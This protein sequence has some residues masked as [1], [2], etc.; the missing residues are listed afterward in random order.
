MDIY[1]GLHYTNNAFVDLKAHG[2]ICLDHTVVGPEGLLSLLELHLGIHHEEIS[3]TDRQA[4]YYAAFRKVMNQGKN[5]LTDSWEKNGL[6]VSNECLKWRDAL[7]GNGWQAQMQQPSKRLEV[8]SQVEA[9]FHAPAFGDRLEVLHPLLQQQSPLPP[10]SRIFVAEQNEKGL[11]PAIAGLLTTLQAKGTEIVY[12]SD[13]VLAA[14][15]SNLSQVQKLL[16]NHEATDTLKE[17]DTS[18]QIWK[19]ATELDAARFVASCPKNA[20]NVYVTAD[21]KLFDNVQRMLQQ[22]TSGSSITNAHPQIAQLFKLGLNLFEYPFNIRNLI[23]WLMMPIHPIKSEL[24]RNLVKVLLSTGGYK[25]EEY[26]EAVTSYRQKIQGEAEDKEQAKSAVKKLNDS[27]EIFIPTPKAEG[28]DKQTLLLFIN[29]L[30]N[31]CGM[32]SNL[33]D[34]NSTDR[35][36]LGKVAGLCKSLASI[37]EEEADDAQIPFRKLEGWTSALY[38]STDF[39]IYSCQAG[40]RWTVAASDIAE[41]TDKIVWTDCYNSSSTVQPTDFLNEAEKQALAQQGCQFW[42]DADY[43]ETMMRAMLR[44]VLKCKKKLVLIV[45]QTNKGEVTSKH[46]LLIRLEQ[47]FSKSLSVVCSYPDNHKVEKKTIKLVDNHSEEVELK[48]K[49]KRFIEIPDTESYSSLTNLIQYPLDY[50]MDRILKLRDRSSAEMNDVATVKGNVAHAVIEELFKGTAKEIETNIANHFT[51]TLQRMTEEKGAILLLQEN[52]IEWRLFSDQLKECL[53]A[54]LQIIQTNELTVVGREHRVSNH[55][56]L[57]KDKTK[58]PTVNG[59]VDMTLQN[60]QGEIF[61]FDFKWTSSQK[62]H[63]ELLEKNASVQLA[64]YEHLIS[65]ESD[66]PVVATAYFTMPWHKLF[67][68]SNR[69]AKGANVEH[70]TPANEEVLLEKIKNSYRYRREQLLQGIIENAE[71]CLLEEIPYVEDQ[72]EKRLVPLAPDYNNDEIHAVNGYSNY[73]CFKSKPL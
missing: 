30:N 32:M 40:S 8:L 57:M 22:P 4:A 60:K 45:T 66:K 53:D 28:V 12:E 62:Y 64:L 61:V 7:R 38:T 20:F 29:S 23:S 3:V 72:K 39:A 10:K 43:N 21:G 50:V 6:G 31:W 36:Q 48:I 69:I 27:L 55:I 1:F 46:P 52:I 37:V 24:R 14:A 34:I 13:T 9:Y 70:I 41:A 49:K 17:K 25:N 15:G 33:E 19:F 73:S 59:F 18:F 5:I 56:G 11:P 16:I 51:E 2:G 44:P 47:A 65:L 68:T 42:E 63:K 58:D 26:Q 54:L 67:T 71:G 35:S